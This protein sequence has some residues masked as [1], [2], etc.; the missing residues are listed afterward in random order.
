MLDRSPDGWQLI[1]FFVD[2]LGGLFDASEVF[3]VGPGGEQLRVWEAAT[4]IQVRG[5]R[6]ANDGT[7]AYVIAGEGCVQCQRDLWRV[8]FDGS[9]ARLLRTDIRFIA[10]PPLAA[11]VSAP[12]LIPMPPA[13]AAGTIAGPS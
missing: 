6:F 13:P 12:A 2:D 9:G 3:L 7:G 10:V 8:G 4:D 11:P 5:A 1:A